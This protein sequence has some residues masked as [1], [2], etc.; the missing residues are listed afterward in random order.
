MKSLSFK[1]NVLLFF[2]FGFLL[3]GYQY[4]Y[5]FINSEGEGKANNCDPLP[6]SFVDEDLIGEWTAEYF[7]GLAK[8]TL[9]INEGG[10]YKQ[11]YISEPRNFES[12]WKN[13]WFEIDSNGYGILHLEGMR[14]CDDIESICNNPGGGLPQGEKAINQCKNEYLLY[15]NNEGFLF[16]V[17]RENVP[18]DIILLQPRLAGKDYTHSFR[19]SE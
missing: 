10:L 4:H 19:L 15:V 18:R 14:R 8:D 12:E 6:N 9:I 16:V 2:L 7:G 11:I 13:W 3:I 1:F 5:R 17:A